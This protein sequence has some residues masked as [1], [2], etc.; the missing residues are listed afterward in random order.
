MAAKLD[1]SD[2]ELLEQLHAMYEGKRFTGN[3]RQTAQDLLGSQ[4]RQHQNTTAVSG[5]E[6]E[7]ENDFTEQVVDSGQPTPSPSEMADIVRNVR[8]TKKAKVATKRLTTLPVQSSTAEEILKTL[9]A[10]GI[11]RP[12]DVD[13][14]EQLERSRRDR[15]EAERLA[16][17][18]EQVQLQKENH[19]L[20]KEQHDLKMKREHL[21]LTRLEHSMEQEKLAMELKA[22]EI[23]LEHK[24]KMAELHR[25]L[26]AAS[27]GDENVIG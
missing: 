14:S 5:S 8:A 2:K 9:L 10:N 19:Q 1:Q 17:M 21:E 11:P 4:K 13:G 16:T 23:A 20:Q 27:D 22:K 15:L 26:K 7:A 25:R 12:K 18:Q 3:F 6:A 24:V